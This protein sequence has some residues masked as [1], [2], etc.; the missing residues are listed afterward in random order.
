M[1]NCCQCCGVRIVSCCKKA[2]NH[3][4]KDNIICG[5]DTEMQ[6]NKGEYLNASF[7]AAS[8]DN[9]V[10]SNVNVGIKGEKGNI[11][12]DIDDRLWQTLFPKSFKLVGNLQDKFTLSDIIKTI[13]SIKT[14]K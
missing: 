13:N 3:D 11:T 6:A 9:T 14:C 4:S 10:Q 8:D 2:T 12:T 1:G 5:F 7:E